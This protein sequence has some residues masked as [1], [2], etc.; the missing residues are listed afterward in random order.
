[1]ATHA[2]AG[3]PVLL[4]GNKMDLSRNVQQAEAQSFA[5]AAGWV[6]METSATDFKT[7]EKVFLALALSVKTKIDATPKAV[8]P[9]AS[10][11]T[12]GGLRPASAQAARRL[13]SQLWSEEGDSVEMSTA[14]REKKDAFKTLVIQEVGHDLKDYATFGPFVRMCVCVCVSACEF[15][16]SYPNGFVCKPLVNKLHARNASVVANYTFS[17]ADYDSVLADEY[18][19]YIQ[20][21]LPILPLVAGVMHPFPAHYHRQLPSAPVCTDLPLPFQPPLRQSWS[22]LMPRTWTA[23][24][25]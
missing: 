11:A 15:P 9:M 4:V 14:A 13:G 20:K 24:Q 17:Q 5:D 22:T 23:G 2:A 18:P 3:I 8:V 1:L 25:T 12:S 16:F 10:S 7:T 6:Y 19:S 21:F